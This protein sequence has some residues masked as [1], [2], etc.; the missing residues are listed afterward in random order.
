MYFWGPG[1]LLYRVQLQAEYSYRQHP[2]LSALASHQP[3]A[4]AQLTCTCRPEPVQS[5]L[6][7]ACRDRVGPTKQQCAARAVAAGR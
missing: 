6:P 1:Q 5:C 3:P 4:A 2:S 7:P